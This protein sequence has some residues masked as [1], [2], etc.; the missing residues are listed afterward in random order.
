VALQTAQAVLLAV[1]LHLVLS[2]LSGDM[3]GLSLQH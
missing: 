1:M 3:V 2:G